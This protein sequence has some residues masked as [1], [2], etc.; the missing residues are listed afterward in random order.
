MLLRR[1]RR[2]RRRHRRHPLSLEVQQ[3]R[4]L[5]L[6]LLPALPLR[7]I[8]QQKSQCAT[9]RQNDEALEDIAVD[10]IAVVAVTAVNMVFVVVWLVVVPAGEFGFEESRQP[11]GEGEVFL[12]S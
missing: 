4:P 7:A 12:D 3:L 1:L 8:I 10:V 9:E 5:P 6:L 11:F 2:L